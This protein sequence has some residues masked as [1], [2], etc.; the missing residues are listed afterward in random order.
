MRTTARLVIAPTTVIDGRGKY[1]DGLTEGD[2]LVRDNGRPRDIHLDFASIP[3]SLVVA[4]EHSFASAAVL[5]KAHK[6]GSLLEPLV[7]GEGGEVAVVSFDSR[8]D[9]RQEF[10]GDFGK[11][12]GALRSIQSGDDGARTVD[13]VAES[14]RLLAARPAERRRVLLVISET[15][16]RGSKTKVEDAITQAQQENVTIYP[17][18][19]SAYTTAFTA[20]AGSTPPPEEGG[21]NILG[22][23]IEIGRLGKINAADA[24]AKYTG[25]ERL[26]FT[27]QRG[28]ERAV[29]RIGEDL[30]SQY[31]LSFAA[32]ADAGS[33]FHAI[34]VSVPGRPGAKVRTRPG[35]WMA[36]AQP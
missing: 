1:I 35:Y 14:V 5:N 16:D 6:I 12:A 18:T 34:D 29:A 3:I 9:V 31:L 10:T 11:V 21:F 17:L 20:K 36:E 13:A 25:G 15:R 27:R 22:M 28:L 2:F 19:F 23:L 30:H 26:S 8:V 4:V 32:P 24:F 33:A 7:T